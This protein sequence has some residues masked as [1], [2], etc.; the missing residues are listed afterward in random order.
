MIKKPVFLSKCLSQ[1]PHGLLL[2]IILVLNICSFVTKSNQAEPY[3]GPAIVDSDKNG[4]VDLPE[5][6]L[7]I[8][9]NTVDSD[10]DGLSD[11][12][13]AHKYLTDPTKMDTDG[14]GVPDGDWNERREYTY[15][16]RSILRF[17][18]PLDK[19]ALNDDYQDARIL[20]ET[21]DYIEVEVIH[22]PLATSHESIEENPNWQQDYAGMMDYLK[23]G[24]TTNWDAKMKRD[25]LAE[26][27][28]DGITIDKLT[29]K[30]V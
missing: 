29:D 30:Q 12:Q 14:D 15:S 3:S 27:K 4:S 17:M 7:K 20:E 9:L 23:P 2:L 25:L 26:L 8:S 5:A 6:K 18:P 19:N 24:V 11:F 28:A 13:E 10:G 21:D 22:Y 16:V 1:N